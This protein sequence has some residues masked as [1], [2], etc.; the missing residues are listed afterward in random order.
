[1]KKTKLNAREKEQFFSLLRKASHDDIEKMSKGSRKAELRSNYVQGYE[2]AEEILRQ[3]A[4]RLNA[5]P[6]VFDS[7]EETADKKS[8]KRVRE[9]LEAHRPTR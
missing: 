6:R 8:L 2:W 4:D 3:L 5:A 1:M 7:P 9:L